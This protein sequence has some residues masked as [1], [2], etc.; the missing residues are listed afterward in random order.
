MKLNKHGYTAAEWAALPYTK[1]KHLIR[2]RKLAALKGKK[3]VLLK[4]EIKYQ[5]KPVASIFA[6][7]FPAAESCDERIWRI[8]KEVNMRIR[9]SR[10]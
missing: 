7:L 5:P 6:A 3:T 1:R 9:R 10:F 8:Q 2:F 4:N